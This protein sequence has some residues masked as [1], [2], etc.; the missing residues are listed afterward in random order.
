MRIN[1][2][3]AQPPKIIRLKR[4]IKKYN[5]ILM[6]RE[7]IHNMQPQVVSQIAFNPILCT[8]KFRAV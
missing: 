6:I 5:T 4:D 2:A 1:I 3:K 8:L 7:R